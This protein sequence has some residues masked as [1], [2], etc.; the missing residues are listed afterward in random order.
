MIWIAW[1]AFTILDSILHWWL[2]EKKEIPVNHFVAGLYR[3]SFSL[4]L[5]WCWG[6]STTLQ[7]CLYL[8]GAFFVFWLVFNIALNAWRR[9]PI[10]YL[11]KGSWLDRLESNIPFMAAIFWKAVL[12]AGMI[13]GYY[14]PEL[15]NPSIWD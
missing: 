3:V 9:L 1:F 7:F 13:Y 15:L 11:G 12:A 8:I 2:I 10:E 5:Y 14:L 6:E 4:I